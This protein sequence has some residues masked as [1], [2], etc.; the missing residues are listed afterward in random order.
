M[1]SQ[2][3]TTLKDM[4][5]Q[6]FKKTLENQ[7]RQHHQTFTYVLEKCSAQMKMALEKGLTLVKFDVPEFIIGKPLYQLND[8]IQFVQYHLKKNGFAVEYRFPNT[9]YVCWDV[10]LKLEKCLEY[11]P[12]V[13]NTV[14]TKKNFNKRARPKKQEDN[15]FIK[16]AKPNK[17][18][19]K[20]VLDV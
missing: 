20:L 19:N 1:A 11:E 14:T 7:R 10:P 16:L 15:I 3:N 18:N 17:N 12:D 13:T 2:G 8:C 4:N 9:L 6:H 5:I